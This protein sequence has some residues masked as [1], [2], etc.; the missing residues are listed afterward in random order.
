M[1]PDF[2]CWQAE[3]W[4]RT[5]AEIFTSKAMTLGT[6]KPA[7]ADLSM[8]DVTLS[9]PLVNKKKQIDVYNKSY[10]QGT[11][12]S[13]TGAK[14]EDGHIKIWDFAPGQLAI[15]IAAARWIQSAYEIRLL[16]SGELCF[17]FCN[18]SE[19]KHRSLKIICT[20]RWQLRRS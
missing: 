10:G 7:S 1:A 14:A 17:R 9:E 5:T 8:I 2:K 11:A 16:E 6:M 12:W 15:P 20:Q 18:I 4:E 3:G 13:D 19:K